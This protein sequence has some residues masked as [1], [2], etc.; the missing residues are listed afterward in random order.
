MNKRRKR[1]TNKILICKLIIICCSHMSSVLQ[2]MAMLSLVSIVLSIEII[3]NYQSQQ[4]Q[5]MAYR[6]L[7]SYYVY[8]RFFWY[9]S[10]V[11]FSYKLEYAH[12]IFPTLILLKKFYLPKTFPK[13]GTILSC[14]LSKLCLQVDLN[15]A[16]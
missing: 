6:G 9:Y 8:H 2:S 5:Q 3:L 13:H 10:L 12:T 16:S 1:N 14:E 11:F 4:K 15:K 7:H